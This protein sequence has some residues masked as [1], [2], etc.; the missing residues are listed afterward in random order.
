[1]QQW[2]CGE[3]TKLIELW[4]KNNVQEQ[5]EGCK[6]NRDVFLGSNQQPHDLKI[7]PQS[8]MT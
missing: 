7:I 1:M 2:Q 5:L 4:S 6:R 8:G 3:M